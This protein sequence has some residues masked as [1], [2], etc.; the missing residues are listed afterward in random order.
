MESQGR[1]T[2]PEMLQEQDNVFSLCSTVGCR[3]TKKE[4]TKKVLLRSKRK[5]VVITIVCL[6]LF[7]LFV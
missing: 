3:Q 4:E 7:E 6:I 1:N 5:W 2:L